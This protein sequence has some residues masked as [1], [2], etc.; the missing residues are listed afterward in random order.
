[1]IELGSPPRMR[2]IQA[3][4]YKSFLNM[5]ITPA[6]AGNTKS[7]CPG[8]SVI[9]DHPRACGEYGARVVQ[10]RLQVGSPPRMRGIPKK[11]LSRNWNCRITP[12]HAG[13]TANAGTMISP[14]R[15]HPR[16]CG[17]YRNTG[18]VRRGAL[19]SPPRMR[20]IQHS[21]PES[22][23]RRRITPAHAGNTEGVA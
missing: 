8:C 10:D 1:M 15:D 4:G 19:G 2:G 21:I 16:A 23:R 18:A 20:G 11:S 22:K 3:E 17:E 13:N 6:H 5:G 12:A 7:P 14:Y 9:R